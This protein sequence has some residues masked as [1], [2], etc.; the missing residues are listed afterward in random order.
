MRHA[1][2]SSTTR[3]VSSCAPVDSASDW[4][5]DLDLL[6]RHRP[7]LRFDP[8]YD[9]R[10]LAASSAAENP[11]NILR[12]FDG[13]VIA[14][15]GA[16]P[17]L[18]L[19]TL[20]D[21]RDGLEPREDDYLAMAP[22]HLGDSRR[23]E[24][25][26]RHDGRIYG[27]VV[28]DRGRTWLQYWFWLYYNPKH[29]LGLGKHEG[30]WEMIQVG[31]GSD[32]EPEVATYAQH[33]SGEARRWRVGEIE[34]AADDPRRP[35]AYVAPL[36]HASYFEP[37]AHPYLVGVDHPYEG[38]PAASELPVVPFGRW[39]DWEGRWGSLERRLGRRIGG[40][41]RSPGRQNPKWGRPGAWHERM[42]YRRF[43][44]LLGRAIHGAGRLTY[45]AAPRIA[46]VGAE[47]GRVRVRWELRGRGVRAGRHLHIT[48]HE[49][50]LVIASRIVTKAPGIGEATLPLAERRR[51][52]AVM[53]S[54]YNRLRQRSDVAESPLDQALPRSASV[55]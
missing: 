3:G 45:P 44:A 12:R 39:A 46:D 55:G 22:D 21:Y 30:D 4:D 48:L 5:R 54:A 25:E 32:G 51:P 7:V 11:G 38:G 50:H 40:G 41:P 23:M 26:A 13:E 36:S 18:S 14:R 19:E 1:R 37:N 15:A 8:Q 9:Y 20:T 6:A 52:T 43:R 49:G 16:D 33:D 47:G 29:L 31:L 17:P 2:V 34:L 24:R 10:V 28:E 53:A 42:R 27:R 35:V